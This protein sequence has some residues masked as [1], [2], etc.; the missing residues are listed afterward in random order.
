MQGLTSRTG[1]LP[2]LRQVSRSGDSFYRKTTITCCAYSY[3][4]PW[5]G[6]CLIV[7]SLKKL[8]DYIDVTLLDYEIGENGWFWSGRYNTD[9]QDP[10]NG[11]E[12]LRDVYLS[13]DPN[14]SL[15]FTVPV[16]YDKKKR[17]IINN[18]SSEIVRILN[19]FPRD[20]ADV[21]EGIPD[22]YPPELRKEIDDIEDFIYHSINNGGSSSIAIEIP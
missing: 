12:L 17:T 10:V 7:R 4:C 8:E 3:L 13:V 20:Q 11:F 6:R 1:P 15:R 21:T 14:Y 5:A 18:E 19:D 9:T 16:L 22:L 2:T